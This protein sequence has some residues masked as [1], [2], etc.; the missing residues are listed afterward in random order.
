MTASGELSVRLSAQPGRWPSLSIAPQSGHTW[1][2]QQAASPP[3]SGATSWRST[4]ARTSAR[5]ISTALVAVSRVTGPRGQRAQP[6]EPLALRA[7]GELVQVAA[8][9]LVELG[10]VVPVPL[11]QL[12]YGAAS[13]AHSS[14]WA[15]SLRRP[16]GQTRFD[17]HPGAVVRRHRLVDAADPD[18]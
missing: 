5:P 12:G 17:E 1:C 16:R 7:A 11:A 6:A 15:A 2:A 13:L 10:R 3:S 18:V 8:A 9:E 14:R 4:R